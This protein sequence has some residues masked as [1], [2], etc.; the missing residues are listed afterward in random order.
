MLQGV[1]GWVF[2]RIFFCFPLLLASVATH[3]T[4]QLDPLSYPCPLTLSLT[5]SS[6]SIIFKSSLKSPY[7]DVSSTS[8]NPKNHYLIFIGFVETS[9]NLNI[10]DIC[11]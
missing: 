7:P 3:E 4:L 2:V 5:R 9:T 10:R 1:L 6:F 11:L 8:I